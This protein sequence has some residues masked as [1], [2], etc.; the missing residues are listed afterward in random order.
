MKKVRIGVIGCGGIAKNKHLPAQ[1][2]NPDAELIAFC[3]IIE[4]KAIDMA[5]AFGVE[6]AKIYTDY[7]ELLKNDE[8]DSV[9]VLQ[10]S[11]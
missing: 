11:S 2:K 5:N 7:T 1:S 4:Q 10:H 3:D 8:V 6:G 9:L